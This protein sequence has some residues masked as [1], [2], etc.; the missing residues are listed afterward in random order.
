MQR[1]TL[2]RIGLPILVGTCVVLLILVA[3]SLL[4]PLLYEERGFSPLR[5][6]E[7]TV[8]HHQSVF[9]R[10]QLYKLYSPSG[11]LLH[12]W[13]N[14]PVS[15]YHSQHDPATGYSSIE[16]FL[17]DGTALEWVKHHGAAWA[18]K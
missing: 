1:A 13:K 9:N 18:R 11:A 16:I 2:I 4:E 5:L 8:T 12:R 3:P 6:G 15:H 7:F 10:D 14:N 17:G